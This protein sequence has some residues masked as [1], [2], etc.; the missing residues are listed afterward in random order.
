M[1]LV[2]GDSLRKLLEREGHL[3]P[4][5]AVSLIRDVCAGVGVAHRQGLPHR[6][7]KPDNVIV[8]LVSHVSE[9]ES[10]KV[11]DFGLAKVRDAATVRL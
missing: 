1:E 5:G 9:R 2:R 7:L 11:I 4:E 10:A 8:T 3:S 6:D